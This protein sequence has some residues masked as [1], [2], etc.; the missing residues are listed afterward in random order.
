[1]RAGGD[2]GDH[3]VDLAY[4]RHDPLQR[5]AGFRDQLDALSDMRA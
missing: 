2:F 1:M 5:L 4:L 3:R